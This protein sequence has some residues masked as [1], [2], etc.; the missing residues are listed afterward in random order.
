MV[1]KTVAPAWTDAAERQQM[2]PA[3]KYVCAYAELPMRARQPAEEADKAAADSAR[4]ALAA[5]LQQRIDHLLQDEEPDSCRLTAADLPDTETLTCRRGRTVCALAILPKAEGARFAERRLQRL[6]ERLDGE[7]DKTEQQTA[8]HEK[9]RARRTLGGTMPLLCKAKAQEHL[10]MVLPEAGGDGPQRLS[11]IRQRADSLGEVL[12]HGLNIRLV[13]NA[14]LFG[15]TYGSLQNEL[16]AGLAD[17]GCNFTASMR[18][19][20]YEI[21]VTAVAREQNRA[22]IGQM[23][24]YFSVI[25]GHVIISHPA[26]GRRL[27]E[28]SFTE[29]GAHPT[30]F[31]T[32]GRDAYR[33]IA[34]R[35]TQAIRQQLEAE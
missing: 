24:T 35:M 34:G 29:K 7:L 6:A 23:T 33:R 18:D 20:D 28:D 22:E 17:M 13:C 31:E 12:R 8:R 16:K 3:G 15:N 30:G 5:L 32:G 19:V 9:L 4:T 2:Y 26:S 14:L 10:L 27:Y 21:I 11:A 1:A 25:E